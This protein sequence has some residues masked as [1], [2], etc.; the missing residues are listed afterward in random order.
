VGEFEV[1]GRIIYYFG[2]DSA[3]SEDKTLR[4]PIRVRESQQTTPVPTQDNGNGNWLPGFG[5]LIAIIGIL[6]IY[7]IKKNR[8]K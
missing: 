5:V 7:I 4:L 3:Q 2:D 1:Q 8:M 6:A